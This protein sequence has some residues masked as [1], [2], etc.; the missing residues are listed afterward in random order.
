M[1]QWLGGKIR[2]LEENWRQKEALKISLF[3]PSSRCK[4]TKLCEILS[5]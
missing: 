4:S 2:K 3:R 5:H 1:L